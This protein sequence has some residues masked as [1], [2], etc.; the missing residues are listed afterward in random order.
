MKTLIEIPEN[1]V[2]SLSGLCKRFNI[3]RAEA[4]RR[5]IDLFVQKNQSQTAD[6]FGIWK[7]KNGDGLNYQNQLR[8][9]W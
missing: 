2:Q 1:Q 5:A 8:D 3:S 6:V 4:I 7:D 9:E